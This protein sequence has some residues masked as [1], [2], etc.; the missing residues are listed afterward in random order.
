M[1]MEHDHAQHVHP[2]ESPREYLKFAAVICAILLTS[3]GLAWLRDWT[4]VG[5]MSNFMA[6]FFLTFAGF[7]LVN[8]EMFAVTFRGYDLITQR[9]A[10]WGY[11][12]PFIQLGLGTGYLLL[13]GL[14]WLNAAT[15][16]ISAVAGVGVLRELMKKSDIPCACL[17]TVIRLPLSR[18]SFVED[19]AMLAM[20]AVMLLA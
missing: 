6:V 4:L 9:W 1:F 19:F 7:K 11:L 5:F 16:I 3:I 10:G 20:A 17:G 18:V 8:L 15:V 13:G 12:Y 2:L 14:L